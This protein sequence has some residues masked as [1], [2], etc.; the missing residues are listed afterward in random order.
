ML[1]DQLERLWT[2][3]MNVIILA[4]CNV[5]TFNDPEGPPYD[6]YEMA[7]SPRPA[8]LIRQWCD[9]VLFMKHEAIGK[10]D[11]TTKR[12]RGQ[13]TDR[14]VVHTKWTAAYDAKFS[15]SVPDELPLSWRS[16]IE[17]AR[18]AQACANELRSTIDALMAEL[19]NREVETKVRAYVSEAKDDANRLDEIINAIRMKLDERS[20]QVQETK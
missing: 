2:R 7:L 14:R 8:G 5:R 15:G 17:A 16:F 12:A 19:N 18:G 4:H 20:K 1:V 3:G 6:R 10:I 13:G 11:S 9:Y